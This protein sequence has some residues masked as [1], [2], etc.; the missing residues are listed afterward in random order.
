MNV[1]GENAPF[2]TW[3]LAPKNPH[4]NLGIPKTMVPYLLRN[5]RTVLN[6]LKNI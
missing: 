3:A 2:P 5:R 4:K 1:S 6:F